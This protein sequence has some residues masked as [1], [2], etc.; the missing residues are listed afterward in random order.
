MSRRAL[1][2]SAVPVEGQE[3]FDN[4]PLRLA[5]FTLRPK[6]AYP[7]GCPTIDQ[8]TA[9]LQFASAT[10]HASPYWLG[11]LLQYGESRDDWQARV[12]QVIASTGLSYK[13]LMN[14]SYLTR[15]VAEPEREIAPTVG[16]AAEVAPLEPESQRRLLT[17]ARDE[18][19]TTHELRRQVRA[20]RRPTVLSGQAE[21]VGMFRVLYVSPDWS[22]MAAVLKLPVTAHALPNAALFLWCPPSMLMANPGPR[23]VFEAW[24]FIPRTGFVWDGVMGNGAYAK[25]SHE[26]LLIGTRGDCLPDG[27]TLPDSV[28]TIRRNGFGLKKPKE[29][30]TLI[31]RLYTDGPYLCL[32]MEPQE[33]WVRL[34]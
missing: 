3:F 21:L 31:E 34:L 28:Q 22:D 13:T 2:P 8:W 18:G 6:A 19:W 4:R 32:G 27:V 26:H 5:G 12:E 15:Q 14:L 9:A 30:A 25:V 16:H 7:V 24:G 20:E 10:H 29:F 17:R 11:S 1:A 33:P 23:D